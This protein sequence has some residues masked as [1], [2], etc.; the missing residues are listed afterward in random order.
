MPIL[1]WQL[2]QEDSEVLPGQLWVSPV[3]PWVLTGASY[4]WDI[5]NRCPNHLSLLL[6]MRRSSGSTP[7]SS[8]VIELLTLSLRHSPATLKRKLISAT[9]PCTAVQPVDT[10][11]SN[12][13]SELGYRAH[14]LCGGEPDCLYLVPLSFSLVTPVWVTFFIFHGE[15]MNHP[16]GSL[17]RTC[18]SPVFWH[19]GPQQNNSGSFGTQTLQPQCSRRGKSFFFFKP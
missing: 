15:Q 5:L 8:W 18:L 3:C 14:A 16:Y 9:L 2:F 10:N 4:L 11:K 13:L 17:P 19:N 12:P 1:L 6:S 7:K